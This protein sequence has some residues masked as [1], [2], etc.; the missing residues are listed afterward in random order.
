MKWLLVIATIMFN[1]GLSYAFS[2]IVGWSFIESIFL[3]GL[4]LFIIIWMTML[5]GSISNNTVNASLKGTTG[6]TTGEIKPFTLTFN[7]F[8][9][10]TIIYLL[11]SGIA[12]VVY[13]FPY[14]T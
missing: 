10:G 1:T 3:C 2:K 5:N 13:Y 8:I 7:P 11:I 9:L 4:L 6:V 12:T 14:F